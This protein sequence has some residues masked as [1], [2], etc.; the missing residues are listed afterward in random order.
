MVCLLYCNGDGY[1]IV[2]GISAA[3]RKLALLCF[4]MPTP[5]NLTAPD[6]RAKVADVDDGI[7]FPS[8]S[9]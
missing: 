9:Q 1:N 7:Y 5:G 8:M 4:G 6:S 3:I 2:A